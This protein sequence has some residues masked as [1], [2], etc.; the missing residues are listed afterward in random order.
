MEDFLEVLEDLM[1]S[2]VTLVFS[3]FTIIAMFVTRCVTIAVMNW[4]IA[5][6]GQS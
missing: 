5:G 2:Q 6:T 1:T 4:E 3:S